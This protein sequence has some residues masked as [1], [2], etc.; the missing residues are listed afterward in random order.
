MTRIRMLNIIRQK[1]FIS[2]PLP[3]CCTVYIQ[4]SRN[5]LFNAQA[6]EILLYL[7]VEHLA[8]DVDDA[9]QAD[10]TGGCINGLRNTGSRAIAQAVIGRTEKGAALEYLPRD[11]H[12]WLSRIKTLFQRCP[13]RVHWDAAC[14]VRLTWMA[15]R[16]PV[17]CPFPDVTRHFVQAVAIGREGPN[18]GSP[19]VAIAEQVLPG[20]LPLPGVGHQCTVRGEVVAPGVDSSFQ[21]STRGEFPL[22]LCRQRL[23][24]PGGVGFGIFVGDVDHRML[25]TP[26]QGTLRP[27]RILPVGARYVCPPVAGIAQIDTMWRL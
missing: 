5:I 8:N 11:A 7:L 20:K 15:L 14:F 24:C 9:A 12:L 10:V 18:R 19:F 1:V 13:S 2:D 22:C 23:A 17:S 25:H 16:I 26:F 4:L 21:S 27:L 3:V 6:T